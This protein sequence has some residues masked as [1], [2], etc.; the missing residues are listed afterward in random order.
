VRA[1]TPFG[2]LGGHFN[3]GGLPGLRFTSS[4]PLSLLYYDN[5]TLV[6]C[7]NC[8]ATQAATI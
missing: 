6:E 1:I 3:P 2:L 7:R 4:A 8:Q 5:G